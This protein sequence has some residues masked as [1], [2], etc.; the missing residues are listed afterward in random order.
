MFCATHFPHS[1][2][3]NLLIENE[4]HISAPQ[5][6]RA[7]F[8]AFSACSASG[9]LNAFGA[10]LPTASGDRAYESDTLWIWLDITPN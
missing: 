9:C 7:L 3:L 1:P 4:S 2:W 6:S 5:E 8:P 10:A